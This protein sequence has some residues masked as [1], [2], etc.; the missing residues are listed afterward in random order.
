MPSLLSICSV[1]FIQTL[2][3]SSIE[4]ITPI[5]VRLRCLPER[6]SLTKLNLDTILAQSF[7]LYIYIYIQVHIH[8]YMPSGARTASSRPPAFLVP[9]SD[10]ASSNLRPET[11][12]GDTGLGWVRLGISKGHFL[13]PVRGA[14]GLGRGEGLERWGVEGR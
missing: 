7:D 14:V 4:P 3:S 9:P 5:T 6:R 11:A 13:D 12:D 1:E 10:P 2:A 8:L